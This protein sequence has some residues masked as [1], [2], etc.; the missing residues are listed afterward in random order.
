MYASLRSEFAGA[1]PDMQLFPI[2]L[3]LAPAGYQAPGAGFVL[4]AGVIAADGRG[5]VTLA[6]ADPQ[7]APLIDPGFLREGRDTDRLEAGL[8]LIREAGVGPAM[9][10]LGAAEVWPGPDVRDSAGLRGYMRRAVGSYYHPAGTCRIGTGPDAVVEPQLRVLGGGRPAG[11]RRIRYAGD[12]QRP[13]QRD[14]AGHRR[15][16]RR[17]DSRPV[18]V[19][20]RQ[21]CRTPL[22]HCGYGSSVAW[23]DQHPGHG[24]YA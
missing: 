5:S 19:A 9:A 4:T 24:A 21:I 22:G 3:P 20:G 13:P 1:Y 2:L 16:R 17:P 8:R 7:A 18:I 10:P 15:T 12:P 6:S 23:N 14:R 11:G